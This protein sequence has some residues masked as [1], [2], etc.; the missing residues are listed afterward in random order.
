MN[1]D[2]GEEIKSG[3]KGKAQKKGG[4]P[5]RGQTKSKDAVETMTPEQDERFRV[6]QSEYQ[7]RGTIKLGLTAKYQSL[8][9]CLFGSD[10]TLPNNLNYN[11]RV[12]EHKQNPSSEALGKKNLAIVKGRMTR[13]DGAQEQLTLSAH[14]LLAPPPPGDLHSLD[15]HGDTVPVFCNWSIPKGSYTNDSGYGSAN[16]LG[17]QVTEMP[18]NQTQDS[19]LFTYMIDVQSSAGDASVDCRDLGTPSQAN[20]QLIDDDIMME[21][22]EMG[23]EHSGGPSS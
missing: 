9:E 17:S 22:K 20:F 18:E 10:I 23:S 4:P 3:G 2:K 6:W 8:C 21:L 14:D 16:M 15:D 7:K 1:V 5:K 11:Y 12:L 13:L 19:S